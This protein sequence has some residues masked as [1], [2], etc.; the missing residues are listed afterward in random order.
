MLYWHLGQKRTATTSLQTA[1]I[2][3][4]ER[5]A[6]AGIVFPEQW[7]GK[8]PA[9]YST[10]HGVVDVISAT[11]E[12]APAARSFGEL[13]RAH[14]DGSVLLSSEIVSDWLTEERRAGM[15]RTLSLARSIMPVTCMWTL[16]RF[17]EL[18]NSILLRRFQV[19]MELEF[20]SRG[21]VPKLTASFAEVLGSMRR[22]EDA[23]GG[24]VSYAKYKRDGAHNLSLLRRLPLPED[25]LDGLER[26]LDRG[27]RLNRQLS[28]KET[29]ALLHIDEVSERAGTRIDGLELRQSLFLGEFEFAEDRPLELIGTEARRALHEQALLAAQAQGIG[30]YT[31]FFADEE[32]APV[33]VTT[34]DPE[35]LSDIDLER[36]VEHLATVRRRELASAAKHGFGWHGDE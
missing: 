11:D 33:D 35:V 14:A 4:E 29:A 8:G 13:L 5:L 23:V 22:I 36:L 20:P 27:P 6:G 7:R 2:A 30:A 28:M 17:D 26:A 9:S 19:G 3:H 12:D 1:L 16:R 31:E 34:S 25:V 10:H 24:R 15:L 32:V 21:D 18:I